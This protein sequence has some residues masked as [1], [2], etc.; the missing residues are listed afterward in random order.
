MPTIWVT[1]IGGWVLLTCSKKVPGDGNELKNLLNS[2]IGV[3][4]NLL[5]TMDIGKMDILR[6]ACL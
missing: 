6:I 5:M 3:Q 1:P 2:L 4:V